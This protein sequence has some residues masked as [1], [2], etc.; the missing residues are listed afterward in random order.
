LAQ[1]AM[2]LA[3]AALLAGCKATPEPDVKSSYV[4]E[5]S[6]WVDRSKPCMIRAFGPF[7]VQFFHNVLYVPM[8]V[9][10]VETLAV[11]DTGAAKS[12]M[13]PELAA[14][15]HVAITKNAMR[16]RG[17]T[18]SFN[19]TL[20]T[21]KGV[22]VGSVKITATRPTLVY[23]FPGSH[24]TDIGV[25]LGLD[26]L[27]DFDWD[28]DV[29]H[30]TVRPYVVRNCFA[31]DPPWRDSYTG[32]ALTPAINQLPSSVQF[33]AALAG[34]RQV[35]VP[36]AFEGGMLE[37]MLDTG[38]TNT[39]LSH[40]AAHEAG[41]TNAELDHDKVVEVLGLSG[42]RAKYYEHI[43]KDVAIGEQ[44]LHDV[45]WLVAHHFDRRDDPD[46]PMALGMDYIGQHRLWLS[47]GTGA[48]YI[49]SGEHR[50]PVA[51]LDHPH[52]LA[53]SPLPIY[54]ENGPKTPAKVQA[55]CTV[56]P[57][58]G[59]TSCGVTASSGN[60]V[61][62]AAVMSWLTGRDGPLMQPAYRDGKPVAATGTWTVTYDPAAAT[63]GEIYLAP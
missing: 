48:L 28:I 41:V 3:G 37:A 49:D 19:T 54:P 27:A 51:P 32:L 43:F 4:A 16:M 36:V 61:V 31:I 45:A 21:L 38:A 18:G 2:V 60:A 63:G 20:G 15:A 33:I 24:G 7:P 8:K 1:V 26:W 62:D 10:G 53:G 30:K 40:E 13:T 57:D 47:F 52:S 58:G 25:Q 12:L 11:M 42:D 39:V 34:N 35:T 50:K 55:S 44:E 22:S 23:K 6:I 59:L 17:S 29:P 56:E 5:R 46:D 9:N 14:A